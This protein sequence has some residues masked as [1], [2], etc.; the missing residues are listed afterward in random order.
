MKF[1]TTNQKCKSMYITMP[2]W[3]LLTT[4]SVLQMKLSLSMRYMVCYSG[5]TRDEVCPWPQN[6][7]NIQA[8]LELEPHLKNPWYAF[9]LQDQWNLWWWWDQTQK[10]ATMVATVLAPLLEHISTPA[11][12]TAPPGSCNNN[13]I[14]KRIFSSLCIGVVEFKHHKSIFIQNL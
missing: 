2:V 14:I 8:L 3:P 4:D 5:Q 11:S 13:K 7:C 12:S 10:A 1:K 9:L 6:L